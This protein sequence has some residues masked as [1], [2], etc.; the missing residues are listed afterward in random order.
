MIWQEIV[1][2]GLMIG[3]FVALMLWLL[4]VSCGGKAAAIAGTLLAIMG[5]GAALFGSPMWGL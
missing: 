4:C 5:I 3:P 1:G 2:A